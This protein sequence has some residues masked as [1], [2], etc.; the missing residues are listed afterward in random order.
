MSLLSPTQKK[1]ARR[2]TQLSYEWEHRM[3]L[4]REAQELSTK[5]CRSFVQKV[6]SMYSPDPAPRVTFSYYRNASALGGRSKITLPQWGRNRYTICHELAHSL[7][8]RASFHG[9]EWRRNYVTLLSDT[10]LEREVTLLKSLEVTNL[11]V[12]PK[13]LGIQK[14]RG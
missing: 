12:A 4:H 8:P 1:Q 11:E 10:R 13:I 2:D 5:Q 7:S 3:G 9:A 14:L 6:W